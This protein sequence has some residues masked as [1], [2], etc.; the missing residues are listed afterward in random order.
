MQNCVALYILLHCCSLLHIASWTAGRLLNF[1]SAHPRPFPAASLRFDRIA[2]KVKKQNLYKIWPVIV[3]CTKCTHSCVS[4]WPS[5]Y[6]WGWAYF[7]LGWDP[8]C[9]PMQ[10]CRA[11]RPRLGSRVH[12]L[13][14]FFVTAYCGRGF[15]SGDEREVTDGKGHVSDLPGFDM[16]GLTKYQNC[17]VLMCRVC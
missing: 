8:S 13:Y 11:E 1:L 12:S 3:F 10:F 17:L 15:T 7:S 16:S 2:W 5:F 9:H 4:F 6:L 14:P